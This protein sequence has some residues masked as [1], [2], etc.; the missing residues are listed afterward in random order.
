MYK[1]TPNP[2]N[3]YA[4]ILALISLLMGAG[5]F[6]IANLDIVDYPAVPQLFGIIFLTTSIY[7]ASL[8]LLRRY[9]YSIDLN[10]A[11]ENDELDFIIS[12][13]KGNRDV[14]VCRVGL[15]DIVAAREVNA[16]NKKQ[17]N[18]ERKNMKRYTYDASFIAPRRIEVICRLDEDD[19][20]ILIAY[21]EQLLSELNKSRQ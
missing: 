14:T 4:K 5:L 15:N 19:F 9:T 8:F 6:I 21:D 13:R 12:E 7:V 10:T 16:Q 18:D 3:T 11:S 20:S 17:V 1:I 2:K